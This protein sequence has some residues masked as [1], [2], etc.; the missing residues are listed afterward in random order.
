MTDNES[1][2]VVILDDGD[3][4]FTQSGFNYQNNA[5]VAAAY[6]GDNYN[7]QGGSGTASWT[8]TGLD[9][10]EYQVDATWAHKYDNKYNTLDAPFGIEDGG[11]TVLATATVNQSN[12]PSGFAYGGYNWDTLGTVNITG[13]TLVVTLGAGSNS[14][15]YTVA[16]AIRIA[17][18]GDISPTLTVAI[19]DDSVAETA[20]AA[21]TTAT[22][23]RTDTSGDLVVQ[24]SSDDTSEATVPA[25][26]TILDGQS[27]ATFDIAAVDESDVDGTQTVTVSAAAT[28]YISASDTLDVTDDEVGPLFSVAANSADKAEGNSSTTAFSFDFTRSSYTGGTDAIDYAISGFGEN[29]ADVNDFTFN[30]F[31]AGTINWSPGE[32][33]KTLYFPV[34]GDTEFEA[35][36]TFIV[37]LSNPSSGSIGTGTANG[38][39][40]NDDIDMTLTIAISDDSISESAGG[41][42]TTAT[43]SRLDTAGDLIVNLNSSD[44]SEATVPATV[45]ILDGQSSAT[46]DIAAVDDND[47][48]GTQTV[49]IAVTAPGYTGGSDTLDVVDDD[50]G[51]GGGGTGT[52]QIGGIVWNDVNGDGVFDVSESPL[53]SWFVFLDQN[54]N[55][56]LDPN[57]NAT[58]T[59]TDG[60]YLFEDLP[61]GTYYVTEIL[62]AG[63]TQT[64]PSGGN[65][66]STMALGSVQLVGGAIIDDLST[67][68]AGRLGQNVFSTLGMQPEIDLDVTGDF[69][70]SSTQSGSLMNADDYRAD[71]LFTGFDGRGYATVI[72]DSGADLDHPFYADRL[73]YSYDF[74][75]SNDAD[76][77]DVDGHGTNVAGIAV[78]SDA[79]YTGTA[80]GS[81]LIVLKTFTDGG[82]GSFGDIEESLQWVVNNAATYNIASINMSLGEGGTYTSPEF[83]QLSD[84]LASLVALDVMVISA[85]GNE[86][87]TQGD[88]GVSYPA[89]DPNSLAVSA[90]WDSNNGGPWNWGGGTSDFTT[91]ADRVTS[92]SSRGPTM[93]DIFAPGAFITNAGLNG[94]TSTLAG[95]SQAAPQVAGIATVA[96]QLADASLGRR[97]TQGEFRALMQSTGV[98]INDG[99]DENDNVTNTGANYSR[100]DMQALMRGILATATSGDQVYSTALAGGSTSATGLNFGNRMTGVPKLASTTI[101]TTLGASTNVAITTDTPVTSTNTYTDITQ[102]GPRASRQTAARPIPSA[103]RIGE[104]RLGRLVDTMFANRAPEYALADPMQRAASSMIPA[105]DSSADAQVSDSLFAVVDSD[106]DG[107]SKDLLLEN[108]HSNPTEDA[109]AALWPAEESFD[110]WL[111]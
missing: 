18:M 76:A 103:I 107:E 84:E 60:S 85:A 11:G 67:S 40:Q 111:A 48:D 1:S 80:P 37:T 109:D 49:I 86:Y 13:G 93:T 55:G 96:Q 44:T 69:T 98:T 74:S 73:V 89:A 91:A 92:F 72:I 33:S 10:G 57:E 82:A 68:A 9:S 32:T 14:N 75:G 41:A 62:P 56:T 4:G 24:L 47:V 17:K 51:G 97:L 15:K 35:D 95:T 52:G 79:T 63:W 88:P 110:E 45:T 5:L 3:T 101:T 31:P 50:E 104:T 2:L 38:I 102:T 34:S 7:M 64:S 77:S 90:V 61:D 108:R 105:I 21:A 25:T 83:S 53:E 94:S 22:V 6:D 26:V 19:A 106:W 27:S 54:Q 8:F 59:G 12:A 46:F 30:A 78:S 28:G 29:P 20:G 87:R 81:D 99:D 36:E 66:R 43:V 70:T 58:Q 39:I 23:T 16:D 71:P 100:V 42:A 65:P